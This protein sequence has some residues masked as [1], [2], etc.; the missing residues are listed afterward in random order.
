MLRSL[1]SRRGLPAQMVEIHL[2][3]QHRNQY[4]RGVY[5]QG[6]VRRA[7]DDVR[8][9]SGHRMLAASDITVDAGPISRSRASGGQVD[10]R[11]AGK[12]FS[13][14]LITS[15]VMV[16]RSSVIR[17]PCSTWGHYTKRQK[18]YANGESLRPSASRCFSDHPLRR[19]SK[20]IGIYTPTGIAIWE[21]AVML[22]QSSRF[23]WARDFQFGS[24]ACVYA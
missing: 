22:P 19:L 6:H 16:V 5:R 10:I 3:L 15:G 20:L 12:I 2:V 11:S 21:S 1:R 24:G 18:S 9:L 23:R 4:F 14:L 8:M 13:A 17:S 7:H